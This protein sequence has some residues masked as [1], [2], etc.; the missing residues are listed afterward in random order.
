MEAEY[1]ASHG[2]PI[3]CERL[4]TERA[5]RAEALFRAGRIDEGQMGV[6]RDRAARLMKDL[7]VSILDDELG[8]LPVRIANVMRAMLADGRVSKWERSHVLDAIGR[9]ETMTTEYK[10][11][12]KARVEEWFERDARR[13]APR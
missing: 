7:R 12:V 10:A 8:F 2:K 1:K 6:L 4:L 9:D 3:E 5:A 11:R 13:E